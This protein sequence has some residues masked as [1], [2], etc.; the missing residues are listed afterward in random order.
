MQTSHKRW[1][2]NQNLDLG[3]SGSIEE[4]KTLALGRVTANLR[5]DCDV[6]QSAIT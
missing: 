6:G 3:G 1:P 2:R 4:D 5:G